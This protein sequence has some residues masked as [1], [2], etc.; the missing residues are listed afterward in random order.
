MTDLMLRDPITNLLPIFSGQMNQ[1]FKNPFTFEGLSNT[2]NG[3]AVTVYETQDEYVF[4]AELA[5]W[6]RDQVSINFENQTLTL[7]GQ[8]DLLNGDGRKYHRVE[9]FYGQFT[10][11]FTVPGGVDFQR[12]EAELK[13]GLLTIHLPKREEAKPRTIEVKEVQ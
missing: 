13:E 2:M 11:S 1:L 7:S 4:Q 10:R 3:P 12:V 9:G 8:R 5:G 6:T